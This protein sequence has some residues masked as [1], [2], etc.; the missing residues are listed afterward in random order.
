MRLEGRHHGMPATMHNT[1]RPLHLQKVGLLLLICGHVDRLHFV[2][3][4]ELLK[5]DAGLELQGMRERFWRE[6]RNCPRNRFLKILSFSS[7]DTMHEIGH[8]KLT[9]FGVFAVYS[10]R[11][12]AMAAAADR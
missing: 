2:L 9:P 7:Q 12:G 10:V 6:W 8:K 1:W 4:S 3:Q 11:F 5:R